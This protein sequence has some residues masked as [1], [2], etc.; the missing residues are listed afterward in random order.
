MELEYSL[1]YWINKEEEKRNIEN[2][3]KYYNKYFMKF[4]S[5]FIKS[6]NYNSLL[7]NCLFRK[8]ANVLKIEGKLQNNNLWETS[9][10]KKIDIISPTESINN[11]DNYLKIITSSNHNYI[12]PIQS[13]KSGN[14]M[15][16]LHPEY[17]P[18]I[19]YDEYLK[20][21][22]FDLEKWSFKKKKK[23][24]IVSGILNENKI[25]SSP[26]NYIVFEEN[27]LLLITNNNYLYVL[28]YKKING[29]RT[30]LKF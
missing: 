3:K 11:S 30:Y 9:S 15:I 14:N 19:I 1:D 24:F 2:T 16:S 17:Q 13:F 4:N 12:I 10:I 6:Q 20:N 27:S 28:D 8:K 18:E 21:T 23:E 22:H 7:Y 5:E 26:I 25:I 29:K